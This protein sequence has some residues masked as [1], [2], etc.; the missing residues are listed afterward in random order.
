MLIRTSLL[1]LPVLLLAQTPVYRPSIAVAESEYR[2]AQEAWLHNDT[3]LMNDLFKGNKEEIRGRIHR[4]AS[5]RDTMMAKKEVYLNLLIQR[6]ED[7]RQ[8]LAGVSTPGAMLPIQDMKAGLA[9]EQERI[10]SDQDRLEA[11][12]RDLPQG[13][14]YSLVRHE[15]EKEKTDLVNLQNAVALR[16]RALD[17]AARSQQAVQAT[18]STDG[19]AEKMGAIKKVWEDEHERTVRQRVSWARLYSTMVQEIDAKGPAPAVSTVPV[20]P[21]SDKVRIPS[22]AETGQS[23]RPASELRILDGQ[24]TYRSRPGAWSGPAEPAA[25]SLSLHLAAGQILGIYEAKIPIR[26][27]LRHVKLTLQ[28]KADDSKQARVPWTSRDPEAHGEINLQLAPDG[29]IFVQIL[30]PSDNYVPAG[31]EVLEPR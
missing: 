13:D 19:L 7:S 22:K 25:V 11:L 31:M 21:P 15:L 17:N 14:E 8:R 6:A 18:S 1:M 29:R 2:E 23:S 10:L 30:N 27:D 3:S 4:A 24:W 28:G 12:M 9:E 20:T 26:G 16:M 5:L